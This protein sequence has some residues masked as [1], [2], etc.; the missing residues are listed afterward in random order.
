MGRPNNSVYP[1]AGA[2]TTSLVPNNTSSA[3]S[4]VQ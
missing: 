4:I 3:G 2:F 1:S